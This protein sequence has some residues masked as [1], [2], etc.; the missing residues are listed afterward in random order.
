MLGFPMPTTLLYIILSEI[1][2]VKTIMK[3]HF[4]LT[5]DL[6]VEIG[7]TVG[8]DVK[9]RALIGALL[10]AFLVDDEAILR[11]YR[12]WLRDD[13][14]AGILGEKITQCFLKE[15]DE[16]VLQP[17]L[18]KCPK[19]V[20]EHF[21]VALDEEK[22]HGNCENYSDLEQFFGHFG[23]FEVEAAEFEMVEEGRENG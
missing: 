15:T 7:E 12:I 13:L 11:H 14:F 4:R 17:V 3:K 1:A 9:R 19:R 23:L 6:K 5:V 10:K 18:E 20:R 2:K 16:E 8:K 22:R 21:E